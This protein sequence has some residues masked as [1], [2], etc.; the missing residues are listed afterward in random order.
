MSYGY[1][2]SAAAAA[3]PITGTLDKD[4]EVSSP[5]EDSISWLSFSPK[6]NQLAVGSWD[7]KVRIYDVSNTS[8]T[9]GLAVIDFEGPVLGCDW[10]NVSLSAPFLFQC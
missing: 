7:S 2:P 9:R 3:L 5:P 8:N 1:R 6:A 4:K 10:S